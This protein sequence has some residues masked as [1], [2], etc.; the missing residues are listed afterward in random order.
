MDV[1]NDMPLVPRVVLLTV[2]SYLYLI[3]VIRLTGKRSVAHMN[4]FDWLVNVAVGAL[5][6]SAILTPGNTAEA[7]VAIA[8]V[9]VLQTGLTRA[10]LRF[11]WVRRLVREE[12]RLLMRNG[13][14]LG[15]TMRDAAVSESEIMQA[16][17]AAGLHGP[18]DVAAVVFEADGSLSVIAHKGDPG[19]AG[20]MPALRNVD[21]RYTP[22]LRPEA[23]E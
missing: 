9:V 22:L 19:Q 11:G 8:T 6:A 12:P 20:G 5:T 15:G 1:L 4:S 7:L 23:A 3:L 18:K 17:R 21:G 13:E 2:A 16:I 10:A 14:M